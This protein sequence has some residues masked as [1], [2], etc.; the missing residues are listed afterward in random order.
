MYVS[1]NQLIEPN[2]WRHT[3]LMAPPAFRMAPLARR[4]HPA[5][6]PCTWMWSRCSTVKCCA[7]YW[8]WWPLRGIGPSNCPNYCWPRC[9]AKKS[10]NMK[11]WTLNM[12]KG[13]YEIQP[14][15]A[16]I[17]LG[18]RQINVEDKLVALFRF[19]G[20]Q[21]SLGLLLSRWQQITRAGL[22]I[23]VRILWRSG[24]SAACWWLLVRAQ[25][26]EWLSLGGYV[27]E[28]VREL[29]GCIEL[30]LFAL[31]VVQ[32]VLFERE[33]EVDAQTVGDLLA[34]IDAINKR[35]RLWLL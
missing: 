33:I 35:K 1:T 31:L 15:F 3:A 23:R 34:Q 11:Y 30:R 9:I 14:R 8:G 19:V 21:S 16:V 18:R 13:F 6:S 29:R 4:A 24:I 27:F 22:R 5:V 25:H 17:A 32:Q 2:A 20:T 10:M 12:V 26:V 28:C 7:V